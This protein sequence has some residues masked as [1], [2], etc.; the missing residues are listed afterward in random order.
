M[1]ALI[2][3][4]GVKSFPLYA[5]PD[6]KRRREKILQTFMNLIGWLI[7]FIFI[8]DKEKKRVRHESDKEEFQ[9]SKFDDTYHYCALCHSSADDWRQDRSITNRKRTK[10][11]TTAH[12]SMQ[13]QAQGPNYRWKNLSMPY[14]A[15]NSLMTTAS[16]TLS[17]H[18]AP[19][20]VH[21]SLG[22][23]RA[24]CFFLILL[25]TTR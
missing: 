22:A 18:F 20:L 7:H 16:K 3:Y 1:F 17:L 10:A 13:A 9:N 24:I 12:Y 6:V 25:S 23:R 14:L 19:R 21:P 15:R 5:K 4:T 2:L 8:S 11:H